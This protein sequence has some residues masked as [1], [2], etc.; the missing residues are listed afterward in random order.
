MS[1]REA[2]EGTIVVGA[3]D[4]IEDV[5][6]AGCALLGYSKD[7]LVGL[8]GADLIPEEHRPAVA[9]ALDRIRQGALTSVAQGVIVRK[10]GAMLSVE[11]MARK[12]PANRLVLTLRPRAGS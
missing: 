2:Q 5:D 12:L 4:T 9:V 11:V 6:D 7:E 10:G 8:H 1:E 3:L